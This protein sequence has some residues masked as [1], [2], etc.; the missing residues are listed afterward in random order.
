MKD[1]ATATNDE[2]DGDVFRM[3]SVPSVQKGGARS[4]DNGITCFTVCALVFGGATFR[5]SGN[6]NGRRISQFGRELQHMERLNRVTTDF[7]L[8][9]L[10]SLSFSGI[11]GQ[12]ALR[13]I[14]QVFPDQQQKITVS[15]TV[16]RLQATMPKI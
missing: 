9:Q 2:Q 5:E 7:L 4:T 13:A 12:T 15:N 16:K 11:T 3:Q 14:L 1:G 6:A 10:Q 8:E